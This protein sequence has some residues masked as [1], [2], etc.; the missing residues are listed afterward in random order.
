MSEMIELTFEAQD[1]NNE[2]WETIINTLKENIPDFKVSYGD[3]NYMT[4]SFKRQ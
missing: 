3:G 4:F 1:V 2:N